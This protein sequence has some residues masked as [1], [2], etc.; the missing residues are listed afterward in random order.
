MVYIRQ[1]FDKWGLQWE[2]CSVNGTKFVITTLSEARG[3]CQIFHDQDG[4]FSIKAR[5]VFDRYSF[6]QDAVGGIKGSAHDAE[7]WQ[8]SAI[9]HDIV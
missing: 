2:V 6:F 1:V 9:Y 8:Y 5:A 3:A 4:D 7:I